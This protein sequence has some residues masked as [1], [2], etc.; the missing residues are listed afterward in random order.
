[1]RTWGYWVWLVGV[2]LLAMAF[3][4]WLLS[5]VT[6]LAGLLQGMLSVFLVLAFVG[7]EWGLTD[8]TFWSWLRAAVVA[9]VAVLVAYVLASFLPP[10]V[11][12]LLAL[13]GVGIVADGM[14]HLLK[15]KEWVAASL[16]HP[17]AA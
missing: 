7:R 16:P 12:L 1:M 15:A 5:V 14:A 17:R 9:V 13:V 3:T 2:S 10:W 6:V 8:E 11:A 4:Q